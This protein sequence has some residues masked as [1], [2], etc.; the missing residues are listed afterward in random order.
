MCR[1]FQFNSKIGMVD[2]VDFENL[3]AQIL[4]ENFMRKSFFLLPRVF[5]VKFACKEVFFP[6]VV[7]F[8]FQCYWLAVFHVSKVIVNSAGRIIFC[9]IKG[10]FHR[11][12]VLIRV[13]F[14]LQ[15]I[16]G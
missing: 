8:Q 1:R 5:F 9:E 2:A 11:F 7:T 3:L 16:L 6:I 4:S 15:F 13:T 10:S 12:C 14:T